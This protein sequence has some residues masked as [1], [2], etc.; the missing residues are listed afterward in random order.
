[1]R[2][3]F[4]YWKKSLDYNEAFARNKQAI[5]KG[6]TTT[7]GGDHYEQLKENNFCFP[8]C[9]F[10]VSLQ[11]LKD[12]SSNEEEGF[13]N[14]SMSGLDGAYKIVHSGLIWDYL[15]ETLKLPTVETRCLPQSSLPGNSCKSNYK[16]TWFICIYLRRYSDRGLRC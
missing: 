9:Y 2:E 3:V 12:S 14:G 1:M 15:I 4:Y 11:T 5:Q 16:T 8:F 10:T 7:K 13:C 6:K